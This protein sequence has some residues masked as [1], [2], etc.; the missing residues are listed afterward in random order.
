MK[1]YYNNHTEIEALINGFTSQTLPLIAWTHEAHLTVALW[2]L[3]HYSQAEATCLIRSG[4]IVYNKASG[5]ENTPQKG[6]HETITLFWIKIIGN[7]LQ[8]NKS[9]ESDNGLN[10]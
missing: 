1:V 10:E 3:Y 9:D 8:N 2:F 5:G 6:Y 4:I 7:Y